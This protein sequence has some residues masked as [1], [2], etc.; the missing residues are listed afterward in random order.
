MITNNFKTLMNAML[1]TGNQRSYG[2]EVKNTSGNI[3]HFY[4]PYSYSWPIQGPS[5]VSFSNTS[6]GIRVGS[7]STPA[8]VNDYELESMITSGISGSVS[9]DSSRQIDGSGNYQS[10]Y[11]VSITNTGSVDVV[12]SEIGYAINAYGATNNGGSRQEIKILIDR[13]LL[14][15]PVTIAPGESAVITYTMKAVISE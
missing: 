8:S 2:P 12:V 7:G 11:L 15:T 13:T 3:R 1:Y 6:S 4:Y 9:F 10:V 5:N 14:N